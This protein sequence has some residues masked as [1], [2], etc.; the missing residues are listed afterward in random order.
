MKNKMMRIASVLLVAALITTCAISGTFAKY[1]TK[2]SGEDS[3]R[4]AK[5]GII[6]GVSGGEAF[7]DKYKTDENPTEMPNAYEG[8]FSVVSS[9]EDKVVAPGTSSEDVETPLTATVVGAPEVATRYILE[10]KVTDVVLPA[11]TYT[12]YTNLVKTDD[13][14]AYAN[15][16]TLAKDYAPVKW[17]L[18]IKKGETTLNVANAIYDN[19]PAN[20]LALAESYGLTR[21]GCSFFDAVAILA[22]VAPSDTYKQ[23]V[24]NALKS[25]VSNG[26]NFQLEADKA[27]G[28]FKLSFDFDPNKEM[29]F[30][31]ALTWEWA[32][33]TEIAG[34]TYSDA[35]V[36]VSAVEFGDMADT[37]LGNWA[38]VEL[39]Q[40]I[41]GFEKPAT[42]ASYKIGATLT[43]T[44]VQID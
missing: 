34:A 33:E 15:K 37:F 21:N 8:E 11:G 40:E 32:F 13:G 10:G 20:Y 26:S 28:T 14:Y 30:E 12:D 2:V 44:A 4:V 29:G 3:A 5:W 7:A 42:P 16:F 1:V 41:K 43:A 19:L 31:F 18:T 22:K 24:E 27:E 9:N 39:G 35:E 36:E 23:V 38:A 25:L 6:L 17:N